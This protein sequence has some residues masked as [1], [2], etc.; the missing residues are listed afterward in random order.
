MVDVVIYSS[1]LFSFLFT[2]PQ[3]TKSHNKFADFKNPFKMLQ[4]KCD[5]LRYVSSAPVKYN[6]KNGEKQQIHQLG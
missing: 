4:I 3:Q 5:L 2:T 1:K 6:G